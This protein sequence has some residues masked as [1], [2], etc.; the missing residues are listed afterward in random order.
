MLYFVENLQERFG[1]PGQ[2]SWLVNRSNPPA[3]TRQGHAQSVERG[4]FVIGF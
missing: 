2:R 3:W 1:K 4:A